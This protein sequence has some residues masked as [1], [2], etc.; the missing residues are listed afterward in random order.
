[1]NKNQI[2]ALALLLASSLAVTVCLPA[3]SE[4]QAPAYVT[5]AG[6]WS[7]TTTYNLNEIVVSGG[8][9]YI[10]LVT[11]N[12][13]NSPASSPAKWAT[14]GTAT[15][16]INGTVYAN[17][18]PSVSAAMAA[19]KA[20]SP[21]GGDVWIP[22]GT[23]VG[24]PAASFFSGVHLRSACN[25]IPQQVLTSI[26]GMPVY[27]ATNGTILQYATGLTLFNLGNLG[28]DNITLDMTQERG[29][30]GNLT[31]HAVSASIFNNLGVLNC[32]GSPGGPCLTVEGGATNGTNSAL[33][34]F[35]G[36]TVIQG[37]TW[38]LDLT[39][40]G[41]NVS[42]ATENV[43]D[44]LILVYPTKGAILFDKF[45]D[46]NY[47]G[48]VSV[49]FSA[50][51]CLSE[52]GLVFNGSP[53][54]DQGVYWE[55]IYAYDETSNVVRCTGY[56][57]VVFNNS[58]FNAVTTG[59][60]AGG[61]AGGSFAAMNS[62][63]DYGT[64][65][66]SGGPSFTLPYLTLTKQVIA[67]GASSFR[68][69]GQNAA[70]FVPTDNL[71]MTKELYGT[72]ADGNTYVWWVNDDGTTFHP[73]YRETLTTPASSSAACEAGQFTDDANYHYV[74]TA[75]NTWKRVALASF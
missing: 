66:N 23:Y 49:M 3:F 18:Y 47:F 22:C 2:I 51:T 6:N 1:M 24:P 70:S 9:S 19:L 34:H 59:H 25:G 72:N 27:G 20:T 50:P 68:A 12:L 43:F 14:L 62:W 53:S 31:L 54:V 15:N 73:G 5:Y 60:T 46:S 56:Y 48:R 26:G 75:T 13:N 29:G 30:T 74:C 58:K 41:E 67:Y 4:A 61:A 17:A 33:N 38:G 45:A 7:S 40:Q 42:F 11:N 55:H 44:D 32:G 8:A 10:S 16:V 35:S 52:N 57:P 36:R 21:T 71:N 69:T 64:A 65:Q 63:M 28:F 39:A 37:G